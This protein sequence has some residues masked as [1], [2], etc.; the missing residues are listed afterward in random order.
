MKNKDELKREID[1]MANSFKLVVMEDWQ[2]ESMLKQFAITVQL[3]Q[4]IVN[5]NYKLSPKENDLLKKVT[6]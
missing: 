1:A 4:R 5:D 3:Y 2:I 6:K